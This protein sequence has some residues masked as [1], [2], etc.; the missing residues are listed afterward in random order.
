MIA[1]I[2]DVK[3]STH[4]ELIIN[5]KAS[6]TIALLYLFLYLLVSFFSFIHS[7][8]TEVLV[9]ARDHIKSGVTKMNT[10][11]TLREFVI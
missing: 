7:S 4:H 8:L 1:I 3:L 2:G 9:C 6:K 5:N 11:P 10:I